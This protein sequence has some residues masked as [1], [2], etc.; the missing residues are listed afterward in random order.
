MGGVDSPGLTPL[1]DASPGFLKVSGLFKTSPG[2]AI[3][4]PNRYLDQEKRSPNPVLDE[5]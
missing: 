3:A 2:L 1:G 5:L 4:S